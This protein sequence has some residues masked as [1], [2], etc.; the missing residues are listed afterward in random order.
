MKQHRRLVVSFAVILTFVCASTALAKPRIARRLATGAWGAPHIQI[1]VTA[2][3]ARIEY[4]CAHG[5][6][7]GPLTFNSRGEFR[8]L[9]FHGREHG[10]PIRINETRNEAPAVYTGW[11][12]GDTMTLTV[13]LADTGET[14]GKFAL[15]RNGRGRVF[16]CR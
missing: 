3:S 13:K 2:D 14:L 11:V 15:R 10:G 5:T 12:K 8:W 6:I 16:K 4:D 7:T 1:D 9:G